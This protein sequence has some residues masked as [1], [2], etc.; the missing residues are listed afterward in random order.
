[1]L[2]LRLG[3]VAGTEVLSGFAGLLSL[4]YYVMSVLHRQHLRQKFGLE[5]STCD[6]VFQDA[7][8]WLFCPPCA[9]IQEALQVGYTGDPTLGGDD[10]SARIVPVQMG[11]VMDV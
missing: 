3:L 11:M 7:C 8:T 10:D 1:M 6:T 9:I 2:A 4:F 5:H